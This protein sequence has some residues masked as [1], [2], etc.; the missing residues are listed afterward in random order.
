MRPTKYASEE[1]RVKAR[2]EQWRK[3]N[4]KKYKRLREENNPV[5]YK[6]VNKLDKTFYIGSTKCLPM[7]LMAHPLLTFNR[8]NWDIEVLF[9]SEDEQAVRQEEV[10]LIRFYSGNKDLLNIELYEK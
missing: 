9:E 6:L 3:N 10:R 1:E 5:V 4:N 8:E 2:R 7:R